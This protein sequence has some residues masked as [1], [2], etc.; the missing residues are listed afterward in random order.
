MAIS[1]INRVKTLTVK[2]NFIDGNAIVPIYGNSNISIGNELLKGYKII[3]F[4]CFVKNLKIFASIPSLP[5]SSLPNFS[6]ED[7]ESQ[8][9]IKVLDTE[10]RNAR[11]QLNVFISSDNNWHQIGS[12]SLL[13]P[14]G[15]P[16]RVYNLMDLFTDNLALELG[17]NSKIGVQVENVGYGL[18]DSLDTVT[19]HGSYVEEIFVSYQEPNNINIYNSISGNIPE[20]SIVSDTTIGNLIDF[21]NT[22][23]ISN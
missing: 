14:Y 18:L 5:E 23:S 8:K 20:P 2:L 10:W 11:K 9:L 1:S 7:S 3:S 22:Q 6:L 21:G 4:N 12:L 17:D 15:Y 19:I 16:F 13:R